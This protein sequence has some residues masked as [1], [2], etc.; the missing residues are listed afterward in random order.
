MPIRMQILACVYVL[1]LVK[2]MI[3]FCPGCTDG[4]IQQPRVY[5]LIVINMFFI[6]FNSLG[7]CL[8]VVFGYNPYTPQLLQMKWV[9]LSYSG[10]VLLLQSVLSFC[11]MLYFACKTTKKSDGNIKS[12]ISYLIVFISI[13]FPVVFNSC[14]ND[15]LSRFV[16]TSIFSLSEMHGDTYITYYSPE[17]SLF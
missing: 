13:L 8:P 1:M 12:K 14:C 15:Y 2:N 6:V 10:I 9:L 17:S 3:V 7:Y 11:S 5:L 4:V 16:Y